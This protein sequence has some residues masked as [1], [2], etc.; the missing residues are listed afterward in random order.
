[1]RS[2]IPFKKLATSQALAKFARNL[3]EDEADDLI[4]TKL[5]NAIKE[6]EKHPE[7]HFEPDDGVRYD[8]FTEI[9]KRTPYGE[10]TDALED[11]EYL[12]ILLS[13]TKSF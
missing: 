9:A 13:M 3:T 5:T 12:L 1:M 8:V 2:T 4:D 11:F 7:I 6:L 10:V